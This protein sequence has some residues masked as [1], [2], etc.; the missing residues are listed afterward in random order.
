MSDSENNS[1]TEEIMSSLK[2]LELSELFKVIKQGLT[3]V[4]KRTKQSMKPVSKEKVKKTGSMP[5]GVIPKQFLKPKA[6]LE[7][8]INDAHKNGWESFKVIKVKK[9]KTTGNKTEEQIE[10]PKSI[11]HNGTHVFEGSVTVEHPEGKQLI[12][13]DAM[14]L[15]KQR[16]ENGH[17][18]W[19]IFEAEYESTENESSEPSEKKEVKPKTVKKEK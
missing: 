14:S 1:G 4:E 3:E 11:L 7:Y 19:A 13:K 15:S 12:Q 5:K 10:M 8:T 16:K 17:S 9:D 2:S 6:W 18:S